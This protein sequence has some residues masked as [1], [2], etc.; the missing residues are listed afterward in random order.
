MIREAI[1]QILNEA[2]IQADRYKSGHQ[3]VIK[4]TQGSPEFSSK[5]SIGDV[6]TKLDQ[7]VFTSEYDLGGKGSKV[8]VYFKDNRGEIIKLS[9]TSGKFNTTFNHNGGGKSDTGALTEVK[10]LISLFVLLNGAGVTEEQAIDSLTDKQA[11]LYD[12]LFYRSAIKQFHSFS[13]FGHDT[14]SGYVGER[15]KGE[16]STKIYDIAKKVTG[17]HPDNWNPADVW[18]F[19]KSFLGEMNSFLNNF[20]VKVHPIIELNNWVYE[21]TKNGNILPVSLKQIEDKNQAHTEVVATNNVFPEHNYSV[22]E[23]AINLDTFNNF[24]VWTES[25][26]GVRVGKKGSTDG[27]GIFAEGKEKGLSRSIGAID[28][29][30]LTSRLSKEAGAKLKEDSKTDDNKFKKEVKSSFSKLGRIFTYGGTV[31]DEKTVIAKYSELD[32]IGKAR[33]AN[34]FSW[35]DGMLVLAPSRIPDWW[36]WMHMS[37]KKLS[38]NSCPYLIIK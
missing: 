21:N 23:V 14:T 24:I 9:G 32:D 18:L 26:F 2:N 28:K 34:L 37:S 10:E 20:D 11:D 5:Y 6:F 30:I 16:Y 36:K 35:V 19:K 4:S 27:F 7:T 12:S 8:D 15:Q 33:A 17:L 29:K 3:V 22:N 31:I 25:G 38:D 13:L 1:E